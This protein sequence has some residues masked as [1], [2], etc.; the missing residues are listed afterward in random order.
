M[1]NG[2][3]QII[4]LIHGWME[5]R[6]VTWYKKLTEALLGQSENNVVVQV[7]WS[8][9]SRMQREAAVRNNKPTGEFFI[10]PYFCGRW[11]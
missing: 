3:D 5:S 8:R 4:F 2:S 9:G 6:N 7:D 11:D 1:V 10:L